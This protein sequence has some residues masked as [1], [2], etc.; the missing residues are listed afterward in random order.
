M[1]IGGKI[2]EPEFDENLDEGEEI[3]GISSERFE[4][5]SGE[6]ILG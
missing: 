1:L 6:T 4:A 3:S 5:N 2:G